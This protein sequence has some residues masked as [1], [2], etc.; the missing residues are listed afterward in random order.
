M[1]TKKKLLSLML[2]VMLIV[3]VMP[4]VLG[5]DVGTGIGIS[6]DPEEFPPHIWGCDARV[7]LDDPLQPGRSSL[8]NQTLSERVNN[9]AFEGEI[10]QWQVLVMDKNKIEQIDEVVATIGSVQGTGND[11]EVECNKISLP[12]T[13]PASCNARILEENLTGSATDSNTQAMYDCRL[14]VETADS[15]YGEFFVTVEAIGEDGSAIMD[16]NEFWF[17]N[18]VISLSVDGD[19]EFEDVRPGAVAYSSTLLVGNDADDGSGVLLDMF[20]SG[21]DFY[22]SASSDAKCPDK[23]LLKLSQNI[24]QR[25]SLGAGNLSSTPHNT[26]LCDAGSTGL[27]S[28]TNADHICYFASNG[29]YTTA[30]SLNADAEGY[31][32][33]VYSNSFTRDFYNDAEIIG[34]T[35]PEGTITLGGVSYW[36]GNVLSPGSEIALTFKLGLPEPCVGNFDSGQL[37]FWGEAI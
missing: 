9:Y 21:T 24:R 34:G 35:G 12:A 29:A 3:S 22:D 27:T 32:P 5:V 6:I 11:I 19:L 36:A 37:F 30:T 1:K 10:L 14:V 2:I 18:P 33:I 20:I 7:V 13:V 31:R 23:N 15:M 4:I 8:A 28:N 16:E 25:A 26:T 17:L